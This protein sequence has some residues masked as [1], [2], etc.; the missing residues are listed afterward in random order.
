MSEN[1]DYQYFVKQRNGGGGCGLCAIN[2]ILAI[3]KRPMLIFPYSS[4]NGIVVKK[5]TLELRTE[6]LVP[7]VWDRISIKFLKRL[8]VPAILWY[9]PNGQNKNGGH[10]VVFGGID[11]NRAKIFDSDNSGLEWLSFLELKKKWYRPY[12]GRRCGWAIVVYS[13]ANV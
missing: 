2:V 12:R 6:G 5:I 3:Y 1:Q 9:P 8:R 10:Y 13:K 7:R 11:G 4:R